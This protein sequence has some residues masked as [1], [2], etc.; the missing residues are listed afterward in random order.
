MKNLLCPQCKIRRF[1]IV[2]A[3]GERLV[4]T[5]TDDKTIRPIHQDASLEGF[6]TSRLYC[7]GCS[8]SGSVNMLTNKH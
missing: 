2:N 1:Y 6:D 4:V 5:V 7:L 8:W 3:A